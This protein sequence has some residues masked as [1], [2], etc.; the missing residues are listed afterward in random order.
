MTNPEQTVCWMP[1][2]PDFAI[3]LVRSFSSNCFHESYYDVVSRRPLSAE[4]FKALD[5]CSLLG[6]GQAYSLRGR[7]WIP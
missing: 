7:S 3:T 4:D 2:R 5:S 6:M 1:T